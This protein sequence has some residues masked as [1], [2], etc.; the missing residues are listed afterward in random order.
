LSCRKKKIP[1][2]VADIDYPLLAAIERF[3]KRITGCGFLVQRAVHILQSKK[4]HNIESSNDV[5]NVRDITVALFRVSAGSRQI[6]HYCPQ[7]EKED[8]A[9]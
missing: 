5:P 2:T 3:R 7:S 1:K 4:I 8:F 6:A 9:D